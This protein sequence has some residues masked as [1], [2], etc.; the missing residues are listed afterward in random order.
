VEAVLAD[1][2]VWLQQLPAVPTTP[3]PAPHPAAPV[4]LHTFLGQF[5]ALRHEVNL[6][7]RATRSQQEQNVETLSQ[8]TQA[9]E[10]LHA[11]AEAAQRTDTQAREEQLRPLLKV[12]VD[13]ADALA[14]ARKEIVRL[15][16]A[17]FADLE[18]LPTLVELDGAPEEPA[19]G[20]FWSRWW[21][22]GRSREQQR[23]TQQDRRRQLEGLAEH[24]RS[25]LE[26]LLTGYTMSLQRIERALGQ[27]GLEPMACT[28]EPFDP[29]RMEVMEAVPDSGRPAGEVLEEVRPG[30]LWHG[31]AFRFALVRVAK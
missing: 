3:A 5:I 1:F 27:Q 8:L 4:D 6:Q 15:R 9:L 21:G 22:A 17:V 7:T 16:Q 23:L 2:R 14:L 25:L 29:E 28:G 11:A 12:L 24:L 26:S 30:Y 31:R 10:A 20:G 13:V 18:R 19:P